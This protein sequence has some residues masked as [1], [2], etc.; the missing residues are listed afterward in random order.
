MAYVFAGSYL[1]QYPAEK[2][3]PSSF[4]C[5][6][7]IRNAKFQSDLQALAVPI[8]DEEQPIFTLLNEQNFTFQLEFINT[9]ASCMKLSIFQ[10]IE[11]STIPLNL[12]SCSDLNGILSVTV[13]LLQHAITIE[14]IL[15]DIQLVG[16]VRIGLLGPGQQNGLYSLQ[17]LNFIQSIY[18]P[19]AQT[20]AQQ[21]TIDIA[22][23]KVCSRLTKHIS[24]FSLLQ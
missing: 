23:T 18:S 22:L 9:N 15:D 5:D 17:E 1:K 24:F 21:V 3:G 16:G 8:S 7:T 13:S 4:A 12:S 2:V 11:S 6:L 20:L 10:V 19:S 14:A